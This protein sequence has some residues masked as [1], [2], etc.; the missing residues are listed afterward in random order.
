MKIRKDKKSTRHFQ[1]KNKFQTSFP[2]VAW[3]LGLKDLTFLL[4]HHE[5]A[6]SCK[7]LRHPTD[8]DYW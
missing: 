1:P 3:I 4:T 2:S 8:T 7:I 6:I 5:P